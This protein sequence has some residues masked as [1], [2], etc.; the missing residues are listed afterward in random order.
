M[1]ALEC[2]LMME[3]SR[4]RLRPVRSSSVSKHPAA[5]VWD[6]RAVVESRQQATF[7][8]GV[9]ICQECSSM[10][11]WPAQVMFCQLAI[12]PPMPDVSAPSR[13]KLLR[14]RPRRWG[15]WWACCLST[16]NEIPFEFL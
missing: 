16:V 4:S 10:T 1:T 5:L 7:D 6:N 11:I 2:N 14:L 9:K 15:G 8:W 12:G 3:G 13:L